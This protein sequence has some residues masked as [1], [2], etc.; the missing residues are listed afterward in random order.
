MSG[1]CDFR[2]E[3]LHDEEITVCQPLVTPGRSDGQSGDIAFTANS[4]FLPL[5]T[6][7]AA[8]H[9]ILVM[10]YIL[11]LSLLLLGSC[12]SDKPFV[13]A[14]HGNAESLMSYA[15]SLVGT[16]YKYGGSSPDTGFDCSG[17]V[18]HVYSHALGI[19]LPRSTGEISQT[20]N[21]VRSNDLRTGDLVFFDTLHR[22]FSHVGIYL[23]DNRFIHAPNSDGHVRVEN[24]LEDYWRH[25]Y[26]GARRIT[27]LR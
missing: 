21:S 18:G 25:S 15:Q 6:R 23:G 26:N 14:Q 24:I 17:F 7:T 3:Y 12:A 9:Y 1:L 16:P 27:L 22:R 20:G 13:Q 5:F 19:S 8:L 4:K 10:K 11:L 2:R